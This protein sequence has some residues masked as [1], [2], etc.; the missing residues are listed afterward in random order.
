MKPNIHTSF[1]FSITWNTY[2]LKFELT[3]KSFKQSPAACFMKPGTVWPE[4]IW[5]KVKKSRLLLA[6]HQSTYP[7]GPESAWIEIPQSQIYLVKVPINVNIVRQDLL[8]KKQFLKI[9]WSEVWKGGFQLIQILGLLGIYFDAVVVEVKTFFF[10]FIQI[11]SG[12]T[13][14][15]I[16]WENGSVKICTLQASSK[17]QEFKLNLFSLNTYL[18]NKYITAYLVFI[19]HTKVHICW[20][21]WSVSLQTVLI[22]SRIPLCWSPH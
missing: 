9:L 3:T 13:V 12:H 15:P 1:L 16:Y 8:N 14:C 10:T 5:I 11:S 6:Q 22:S 20:S 4:P 17:I 18:P 21:R 2:G 19:E 7:K